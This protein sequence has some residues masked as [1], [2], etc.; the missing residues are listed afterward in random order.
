[1][2]LLTPT[3]FLDYTRGEEEE[4]RRKAY[5]INYIR[6]GEDSLR[7]VYKSRDNRKESRNGCDNIDCRGREKHIEEEE[8][9]ER[10]HRKERRDNLALG[11]R[12]HKLRNRNVCRAREDYRDVVAENDA[13][14]K[15]SARCRDNRVCKRESEREEKYAHRG[16]EF[17]EHDFRR[18]DGSGE[19][20]LVCLLLFLFTP[21]SH[22]EN[23]D[24]EGHIAENNSEYSHKVTGKLL[25]KACLIAP[26]C[27]EYKDGTISKTYASREI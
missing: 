7:E 2:F 24:K 21:Y 20:K 25:N 18:G 9:R 13:A 5:E 3:A 19:E 4:Q 27:K 8:R 14:L 22:C 6:Q 1:M 11:E 23:G 26:V 16:K 17:A 12:G 15:R 10:E